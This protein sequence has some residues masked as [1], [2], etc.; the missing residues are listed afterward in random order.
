[1]SAITAS[2]TQVKGSE[3][4]VNIANISTDLLTNLKQHQN[5][6]LESVSFCCF[7]HSLIVSFDIIIWFFFRRMFLHTIDNELHICH[8]YLV[9]DH[10]FS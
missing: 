2:I 10:V 8:S 9:T 6:E 7:Y 5:I 1:M 4:A 3:E